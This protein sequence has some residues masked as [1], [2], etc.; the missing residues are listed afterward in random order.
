MK[1]PRFAAGAERHHM[2]T[3]T[4]PPESRLVNEIERAQRLIAEF[5]DNRA[6]LRRLERIGLA[7][8]LDRLRGSDPGPVP[9]RRAA[10]GAPPS[11][12]WVVRLL[13]GRRGVVRVYRRAA[14]DA[15]GVSD[16]TRQAPAGAAIAEGRPGPDPADS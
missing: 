11:V 15:G 9:A 8:D 4:L 14:A 10:P 7:P 12:S 13:R 3:I 16:P 2:I 5:C 1:K 6:A